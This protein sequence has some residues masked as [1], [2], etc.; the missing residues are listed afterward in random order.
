MDN[1][2]GTKP[3]LTWAVNISVVVLVLAWLIPTVGLLVSS[4]RDR[5][6]IAISAWWKSPF[7]VEQNFAVKANLDAVTERDG[8]YVIEGNIFAEGGNAGGEISAFGGRRTD[9]TGSAP[10]ETA[11]LTRDRTLTVMANGDYVYTSPKEIKR[12]PSIYF[13]AQ[14][15][16]DFS[17]AN[18]EQIL[19]SDN[20]DRAFVNTL[21]V[22][23]PATII[24][25]MI[26]AFAAE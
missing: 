25:I 11:E 12:A 17:L 10:G 7:P 26:A 9:P 4:F 22:T 3:A 14:T 24:P 13:A 23:I 18:Y 1:I 21:T 5:E 6:Q 16:P 15:P 20:M 19:G 8:V 2:A